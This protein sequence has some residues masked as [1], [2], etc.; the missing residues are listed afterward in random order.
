MGTNKIIL[1]TII[2]AIL[3][4]TLLFGK[5]ETDKLQNST[6]KNATL[7][8]SLAEQTIEGDSLKI[9]VWDDLT[10]QIWRMQDGD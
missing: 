10:M 4:S 1:A 9:S 5:G 6:S 7:K 8:S 2:C 3:S